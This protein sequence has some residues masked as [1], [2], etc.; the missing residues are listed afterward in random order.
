L[1]AID[2]DESRQII[3]AVRLHNVRALPN[4]GWDQSLLFAYL[5]RDA[6]KLDIW[7]VF[8]DCFQAPEPP[9][10]TVT[11]NLPERPEWSQRIVAAILSERMAKIDD[12]RSLN[13]FKLLQLGWIFDLNFPATVRL[14]KQNGDLAAIARSLPRSPEIDRAVAIVMRRLSRPAGVN[15]SSQEARRDHT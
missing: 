3:Q 4:S 12:M 13:D 10:P 5:I 6:D 9:H 14:A 15:P 7:K 11:L 2:A 8:A 1:T